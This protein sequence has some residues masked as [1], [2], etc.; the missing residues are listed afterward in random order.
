MA[1]AERDEAR[2]QASAAREDAAK[3]A[4][5]IE[6]MQAQIAELMHAIAERKPAAPAAK[7]AKNPAN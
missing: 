6:A 7:T 3:L 2:Q 5:K 4:G 1:Q